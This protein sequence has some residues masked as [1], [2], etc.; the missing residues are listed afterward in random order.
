SSTERPAQQHPFED[1]GHFDRLSDRLGRPPPKDRLGSIR[2]TAPDTSTGSVT[3]LA[4]PHRKTLG[5]LGGEEVEVE[6]SGDH[7][8]GGVT[9]VERIELTPPRG[10]ARSEM[11]RHRLVENSR[12]ELILRLH[13]RA[14]RTLGE[15]EV[16]TAQLAP[17]MLEIGN[18][19]E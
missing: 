14:R 9:V 11:T 3:G 17:V 8:L 5:G 1:A 2:S 18:E 15:I 13:Q 16:E 10:V 7:A 4:V 6:E 12:D 19:E